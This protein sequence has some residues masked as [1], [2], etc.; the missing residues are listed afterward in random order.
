MKSLVLY[1]YPLQFDGV[2]IQGEMLYKGLLENKDV[3]AP[4]SRDAEMEKEWYYNY[5]KPDVCI[6]VGFWGDY[7]DIIKHPKDHGIQPVPWLN[8]DGWV[9]NYID[10]LNEL[11]LIL[12]TSEWV[13]QTYIRDGVSGKNIHPMPIGIDMDEMGPLPKNH[14]AVLEFRK[15]FGVEKGQKMILTIG[16]DTTSKGS[17]EILKA[18]AKVNKEFKDWV[19]V[20]KS[21]YCPEYHREEEQKIIDDYKL[22]EKKIHFVEGPMSRNMMRAMLSA[23]DIYAAPSRIEGFGM[24][25]VE[26]QACGKPVVSI[27]AMGIKDTV[28]NNK[29]GLLAKVGEEV[30]LTEEWVYQHQGFSR[31]MKIKFDEP[32]VFAVRADIDDLANHLLSLLTNDALCDKMGHAALKHARQKFD[33]RK[34]SKDISDLIKTKLGID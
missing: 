10:K 26:A 8:A 13:R 31:K 9:S 19:Y 16:G 1:P 25:Q 32:K 23:C 4:C 17:Q 15:M 18:L 33:Y 22:D 28:V 12:T 29:T 30:K 34:T 3:A 7:P 20:G 11:P 14:P 2:S 24:I 6:G 27:D 21:W 5:L